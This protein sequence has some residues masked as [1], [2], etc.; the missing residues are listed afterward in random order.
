[1][2]N[3]KAA[4][5]RGQIVPSRVANLFLFYQGFAFL[6]EK[7][8][9]QEMISQMGR[10]PISTKWNIQGKFLSNKSSSTVSIN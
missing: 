8:R 7:W 1:M 6:D 10:A 5:N 4:H 2:A 9:K 3:G